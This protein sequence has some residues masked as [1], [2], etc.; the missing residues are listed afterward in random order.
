ME[1]TSSPSGRHGQSVPR[2]IGQTLA[3]FQHLFDLAV[4][5]GFR[6]LRR[7]GEHPLPEKKGKRTLVGFAGRV[8]KSAVGFLGSLGEEYYAAYERLKAKRVRKSA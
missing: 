5:W 8:F 4:D 2:A 6:K 7:V 3:T 1:G